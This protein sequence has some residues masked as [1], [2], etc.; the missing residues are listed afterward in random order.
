[1]EDT[2]PP[3]ILVVDDEQYLR[4]LVGRHLTQAGYSCTLA[5]TGEEAWEM[6]QRDDFALT[7]LDIMLPGMS[8]IDLLQKIAQTRSD[9]AVIMVTG[10]DDRSTAIRALQLGAYG[11]VIKPY[12]MNELVISVVNALERR[13]L[14][15]A[16]R[17]HEQELEQKVDERTAEVR[18]T[19]EEITLRLVSAVEHRDSETGAHAKRI[20]LYASSLAAQLGWCGRRLEDMRLA[21]PMHDIGKVGIPDAIL[22]K[23]G[24]LTLDEFEVIKKHPLIGAQI[25][26]GVTAPLLRMAHDIAL[27]HQEKWDG[28]GYPRG[29]AGENIPVS[30]RIVTLTDVYDA[31]THDRAYR[32]ALPEAEVL[33]SIR[34]GRGRH[35]DPLVVDAFL[36]SLNEFQQI[37]QRVQEEIRGNS[38]PA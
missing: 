10:V 37:R 16:S 18:A 28:S 26:S 33:D 12:E 13:R 35:F 29:I 9:T 20:G 24:R 38:V 4:Q 7:V 32:Q 14:V 23:R 8:G 1:M 31:M 6:L 22:Q 19:Q 3:R 21:A 30:A 25:L 36:D 2:C 27:S 17:R 34:Q 11:Y 15:I 5:G